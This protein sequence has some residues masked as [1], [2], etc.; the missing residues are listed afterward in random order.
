MKNQ[1]P[2]SRRSFM[3][4]SAAVT[5][6]ALTPTVMTGKAHANTTPG[7]LNYW[8]GRSVVNYDK[9]VSQGTAIK[10]E[11]IRTMVDDSIKELTGQSTV[12]GAWASLF[13]T[14]TASTK[15]AI[16]INFLNTIIASHPYLVRAI[17][18]GLMKMD[19]GGGQTLPAANITIWEA[20]HS[21]TLVSARFYEADFYGAKLV[22]YEKEAN[23]AHMTDYGD[24]PAGNQP[25]I[26]DLNTA[27]YLI[28]IPVLKGHGDEAW[29][30]KVTL[31]F[32]SHYGTFPPTY[33]DVPGDGYLR[34][35]NCAGPVYEKTALTIVSAILANYEGD[36]EHGTVK[37][38]LDYGK[39]MDPTTTNPL[40]NTVVM[41]T[42]PIT[43]E[44]QAIKILRVQDGTPYTV[45]SMPD[46]LKASAGVSGTLT[47]VYNIGIIDESAMDT[48]EIINGQVIAVDRGPLSG[49]SVKNGSLTVHPNPAR[50]YALLDLMTPAGFKGKKVS[51][52]IFNMRGKLVRKIDRPVQG[53]KNRIVWDGKDAR[54]RTVTSG[55]Y[56]VKARLGAKVLSAAITVM[57]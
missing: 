3:K 6:A 30:G 46:Y 13:P 35:I 52:E 11:V 28:N 16:K 18:E 4:K 26:P 21:K 44:F 49:K 45:A 20:N 1:N 7:P 38:F 56:V 8:P 29:C 55:R 50:S 40:T 53:I 34:D 48:R 19:V 5:A 42:D 54:N 27:D 22:R 31:G 9:N 2:I 43:A 33:H 15:I 51:L 36:S 17:V 37:T 10:I 25:Y 47:P 14:L 57:Q 24:G 32:K 41:S 39:T 12:A 23:N